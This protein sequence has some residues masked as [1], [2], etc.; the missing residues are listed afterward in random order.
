ML[1]YKNLGSDDKLR[2]VVRQVAALNDSFGWRVEINHSNRDLQYSARVCWGALLLR[3]FYTE[4]VPSC[5][6]HTLRV[7]CR[8]QYE[9]AIAPTVSVVTA[10]SNAANG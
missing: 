2:R 6:V 8:R 10:S 5:D 3:S 1:H 4:E 7:L 9:T